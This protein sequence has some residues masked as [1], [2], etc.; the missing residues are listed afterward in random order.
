MTRNEELEKQVSPWA[1]KLFVNDFMKKRKK[2]KEI[3]DNFYNIYKFYPEYQFFVQLY[4]NMEEEKIMAGGLKMNEAVKASIIAALGVCVSK[5]ADLDVNLNSFIGT[6][7]VISVGT[8]VLYQI[9]KDDVLTDKF[10][11]KEKK[12]ILKD[13]RDSCDKYESLLGDYSF[14]TIEYVLDYD[15]NDKVDWFSSLQ[16]I[17]TDNKD[18]IDEKKKDGTFDKSF[19]DDTILSFHNEIFNIVE[20]NKSL[21]EVKRLNDKI[22]EEEKIR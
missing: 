10:T 9:N 5:M 19:N 20:F 3:I 1:S 22:I 12:K 17:I 4:K 21:E 18:Y 15:E 2:E 6:L 14:S 16:A 11:R 8:E 7:V 13:F